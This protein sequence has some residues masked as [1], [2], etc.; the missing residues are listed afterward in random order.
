MLVIS[1]HLV[2]MRTGGLKHWKKG[3]VLTVQND[4]VLVTADGKTIDIFCR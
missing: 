3:Q 2:K 1:K 4:K